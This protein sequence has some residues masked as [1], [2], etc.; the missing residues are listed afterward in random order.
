MF[1]PVSK[2]KKKN[3]KK[4]LNDEEVKNLVKSKK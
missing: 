4:S 3:I 2:N 1:Q